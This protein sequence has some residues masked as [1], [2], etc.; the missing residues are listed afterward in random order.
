MPAV[1]SGPRTI[2]NLLKKIGN[3][4]FTSHYECQFSLPNDESGLAKKYF[5]QRGAAGFIGSKVNNANA[6]IVRLSCAEASL[7]GSSLATIEIN[8]DHSGVTEK[9]AYR[10]LYDNQA[11]FTFYVDKEYRII[12]FFENWIAWISGENSIEDQKSENYNYRFNFPNS[13]KSDSLFITKFE[14]D[15]TGRRLSYQFINAFPISIN[16]MPVSYDGSNLLKCTVG[17]S[18]IRYVTDKSIYEPP[19]TESS[20]SSSAATGVPRVNN[21]RED[22]DIWSLTNR[23]M[24]G[25]FGTEI[26]RD[27]LADVDRYYNTGTRQKRLQELANRG[28][29]RAGTGGNYDGVAMPG[30]TLNFKK[31][32]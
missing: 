2:D 9:H 29:Y 6:E 1:P 10:R 3:A 31:I 20:V 17:F 28:G 13:Y 11:S 14:R 25:Q 16:S 21:R 8:N 4:A 15:Y 12:D 18:Y 22:L 23:G 24:I 5:N 27:I 7:P 32:Q 19:Q 30:L 26:Q